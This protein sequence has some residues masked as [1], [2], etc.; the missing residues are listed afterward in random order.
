[1]DTKVVL[2]TDINEFSVFD[3]GVLVLTGS[4]PHLSP[5]DGAH[6]EANMELGFSVDLK[7]GNS[8]EKA[9]LVVKS[10]IDMSILGSPSSEKQIGASMPESLRRQIVNGCTSLKRTSQQDLEEART[11]KRVKVESDVD[12]SRNSLNNGVDPTTP[13]IAVEGCLDTSLIDE[14]ITEKDDFRPFVQGDK[15]STAVRTDLDD[16]LKAFDESG[17]SEGDD[18]GDFGGDPSSWRSLEA[19]LGDELIRNSNVNKIEVQVHTPLVESVVN[20]VDI[21]SHSDIGTQVQAHHAH[22]RM[23]RQKPSSEV[24]ML[25]SDSDDDLM[26]VNSIDEAPQSKNTVKLE[27][28]GWIQL[29]KESSQLENAVMQEPG[30]LRPVLNQNPL[31]DISVKVEHGSARNVPNGNPVVENSLN[32]EHESP[33]QVSNGSPQ[34]ENSVKVEHGSTR[35]V[36][37]CIQRQVPQSMKSPGF[38]AVP[39][40]NICAA[41]QRLV[42]QSRPMNGKLEF[43]FVGGPLNSQNTVRMAMTPFG[44]NLNHPGLARMYGGPFVNSSGRSTSFAPSSG[45]FTDNA[46]SSFALLFQCP[47]QQCSEILHFMLLGYAQGAISSGEQAGRS[48][49]LN[50][51]TTSAVVP[52]FVEQAGR[53][54]GWNPL[55]ASAAVS[56]SRRQAVPSRSWNPPTTSAAVSSSRDQAGPSRSWNPATTSAAVPSFGEQGG[57]SHSGN[58]PSTYALVPFYSGNWF[59]V[60]IF[61]VCIGLQLKLINILFC[62]LIP[63]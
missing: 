32:V 50:P 49:G 18:D 62:L 31:V 38:Q 39:M 27:P 25:D 34:V 19:S 54:N 28:G 17:D 21:P 52:S 3:A 15:N 36:L 26:I 42:L 16:L 60:L 8:C 48:H 53:R 46:V 57:P 6:T 7:A 59:S 10:N 9:E 63:T 30:G 1:M 35:Q 22:E 58:P 29:P 37:Q 4:N 2:Y 41:D 44:G 40:Q 14:L 20:T 61:R 47:I 43:Y 55:M 56:S 12:L 45:I 11:E 13:P 24:I 5:H 23:G 51:P 33:R